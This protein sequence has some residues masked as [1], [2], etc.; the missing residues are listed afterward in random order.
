MDRLF[1]QAD[2]RINR[3]NILLRET[4]SLCR[5]VTFKREI[6]LLQHQIDHPLQ[7]HATA[8]LRREYF[9]DAIPFDLGDLIRH[10][11]PA[12]SAKNLDMPFATLP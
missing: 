7:P 3:P 8:I 12:A 2:Q 10:N 6:A 5:N 11:H 4:G 1:G 9:A